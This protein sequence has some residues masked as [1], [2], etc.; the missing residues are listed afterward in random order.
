MSASNREEPDDRPSALVDKLWAYANVLRDDGV[1]TIDYTEQLTYLLFLKMAHERAIRPLKPEV[2]VPEEYSWQRLLD[3]ET[4]WNSRS[5]TPVSSRVSRVS[6]RTL[7]TIF[8]NLDNLPAPEVIAREIVEDLTA[9][10]AE[11]EAVASAL[12]RSEPQV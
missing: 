3:A 10:L 4:E 8:R 9:A 11:F 7:G 1:G 5:S 12:E 2:I 6:P